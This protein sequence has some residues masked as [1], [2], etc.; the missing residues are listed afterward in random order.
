MR[1]GRRAGT[2]PG[3]AVRQR[4]SPERAARPPDQALSPRR[5]EDPRQPAE[6]RGFRPCA[7]SRRL[8]HRWCE[9]CRPAALRPSHRSAR[10]PRPSPDGL[11]ALPCRNP[12]MPGVLSR[13]AVSLRASAAPIAEARRKPPRP[14]SP[15]GPVQHGAGNRR[16]TERD[17]AAARLRKDMSDAPAAGSHEVRWREF[18]PT[19]QRSRVPCRVS[20]HAPGRELGPCA[21]PRSPGCRRRH[22]G[23]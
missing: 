6:V 14:A 3:P 13:P 9:R 18:L 12:P 19:N 5:F 15:L 16:R 7:T 1:A 4:A 17:R 11:H 20:P 2:R 8:G 23:W 22:A 10:A 21:R